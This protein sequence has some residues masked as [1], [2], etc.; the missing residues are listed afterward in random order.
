V[1]VGN[2]FCS[3]FLINI[4]ITVLQVK[5]QNPCFEDDCCYPIFAFVIPLDL[6]IKV[7]NLTNNIPQW[8]LLEPFLYADYFY[9]LDLSQIVLETLV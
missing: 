4:N 8:I 1:G 6:F 3:P 5:A 2:L 9:L 7:I